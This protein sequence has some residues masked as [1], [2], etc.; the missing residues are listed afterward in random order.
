MNSGDIVQQRKK[1]IFSG[2]QPSGVLTLGNYLGAMRN[3]TKL[4]DEADCLYCVVD[5]HAITVRQVPAELRRHTYET[6]ALLVASGLDPDKNILFVQSHVPAHTQLAWVLNC[7]SM[8]GELSRMTQF[9]EK[10]AKHSD[11]INA[12]LF[13]Y[14][15]LMAADILLY[16]TDLVPVG[17]DQKQHL[18]LARDIAIRFNNIYGETFRVPEGYIPQTGAKIMSLAD[19]TKKMSKSDENE[20]AVISLLDPRDVIIRKFK[21]AVTDSGN[22]IRRGEGK[23]GIGNL[24][25]IYSCFTGKTDEEIEREFAG[26]G[27]GEF[28]MAVAE[29]TADGLKPIQDKFAELMAEKTYLEEIMKTGAERAAKIAARTL[30]KVYRKVGF[31]QI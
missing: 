23:E 24:M 12:G 19:P 25:T 28:K 31:V 8:F 3:W 30:S 29:V 5:L 20:N 11:N 9:K 13:T 21:R 7:F 4:Q 22:E 6:L 27:Y 14:P 18:E 2:I 15:T 26:K 16:Q 17:Q 1:I 10:S